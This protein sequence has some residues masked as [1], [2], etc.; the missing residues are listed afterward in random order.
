[1]SVETSTDSHT[2]L[3]LEITILDFHSSE[4]QNGVSSVY[5]VDATQY[6]GVQIKEIKLQI[7]SGFLITSSS[8]S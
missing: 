5:N 6:R 4:Q 3:S 1:M 8:S 2:W 7:V